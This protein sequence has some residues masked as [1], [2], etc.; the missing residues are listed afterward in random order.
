MLTGRAFTASEV[1]TLW[2]DRNVC[3]IIIFIIPLRSG[4]TTT[5]V[6]M[7][8]YWAVCTCNYCFNSRFPLFVLLNI[9]CTNDNRAFKQLVVFSVSAVCCAY[10]WKVHCAVVRTLFQTW[11]HSA[12]VTKVV[13][14]CAQCYECQR[15]EIKK[16]RVNHGS[17]YDS[18]KPL[19]DRHLMIIK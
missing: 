6:S 3:I 2:R 17:N 15:E 14:V 18:L 11:R 5:L 16:A 12:V 19:T 8:R 10:V 13:T 1:T 7:V 9:V 4:T